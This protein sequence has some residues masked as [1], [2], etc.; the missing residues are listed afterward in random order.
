MLISE[1][2]L[3]ATGQHTIRITLVMASRKIVTQTDCFLILSLPL[4]KRKYQS[5]FSVNNN[6]KMRG[7]YNDH[8]NTISQFLSDTGQGA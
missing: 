2:L 6:N 4:G 5:V 7:M 3:E 8:K 1:T